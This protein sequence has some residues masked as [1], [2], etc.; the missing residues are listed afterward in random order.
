MRASS[1]NVPAAADSSLRRTLY[2]EALKHG[3]YTTLAARDAYRDATAQEGGMHADLVLLFIRVQALL[4]TPIAP[5]VAEELWTSPDILGER[6]SIQLAHFPKIS[7]P[8]DHAC[9]DSGVYVRATLK[10]IRDADLGFVKRLAK[11]KAK[12]KGKPVVTGYDP[13]K[14]KGVNVY[15]SQSLPKWQQ[16]V[17]EVV[18]ETYDPV[19]GVND[20][21]VLEGLGAAGM[22]GGKENVRT[23]PFVAVLKVRS[24][25][26]RSSNQADADVRR[27]RSLNSEP[28]LRSIKRRR[29]TRRSSSRR[30]FR[31]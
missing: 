5:H 10:S 15:I 21:K 7:A 17:V 3:F 1:A 31:I 20:A 18:K 24:S 4:I 26:P 22:I 2:K 19:T 9:L 28:S 6:T 29:T 12:A 27:T 23:M 16:T 8:V 14:P 25:L 13:S 30:R 11:A